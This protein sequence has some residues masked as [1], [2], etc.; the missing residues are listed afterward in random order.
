[1]R[2]SENDE[3]RG[4]AAVPRNDEAGSQQTGPYREQATAPLTAAR[5]TQADEQAGSKS[6]R[7]QPRAAAGWALHSH[8]LPSEDKDHK[9]C[10]STERRQIPWFSAS[11]L[12]DSAKNSGSKTFSYSK[13]EK[14]LQEM[15]QPPPCL[16]APSDA[17]LLLD[18]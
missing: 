3:I 2:K 12:T 17:L 15:I 8:L 4:K 18:L 7:A 1:M 11:S 6:P 16:L 9:E 13:S 14:S 10:S 5:E